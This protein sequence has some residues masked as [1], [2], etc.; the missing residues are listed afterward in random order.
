[1]FDHS[2]P[3]VEYPV[4]KAKRNNSFLQI[5]IVCS[6]RF[7][8]GWTIVSVVKVKALTLH[9]LEHLLRAVKAELQGRIAP[10]PT[11]EVMNMC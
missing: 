6:S 7:S 8:G 1:M 4:E 11:K 3:A 9:N 5:C 10:D 2:D